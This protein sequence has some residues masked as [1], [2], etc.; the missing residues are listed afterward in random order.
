[1]V[2]L[3]VIGLFEVFV[4]FVFYCLW[5]FV[6]IVVGSEMQLRLLVVFLLFL[7]VQL[8]NFSVFVFCFGLFCFV[9]SSMNV[10]LMIGYVF[11]FGW[12]VRIWQNDFDQFVLVVVVLN[13][14]VFG[15]IIVF[16][17]F[18]RVVQ[19]MLFFFVYVYLM[20]LIVFGRCCMK[21]V[22]LL[23]FL[24]FVFVGQLIVVFLLIFDF[25]LL[26]IFDRQFVQM[27]FVF[28]LLVWWIM[29][30]FVFGS[31][32]FGFSV[33][34][35]GLFYFLILLR[36]MLLSIGFDSVSLLVFMFGMLM[37]GIML[38]I[39]VGNWNRFFF[40]SFLFFSGV[41]ELVKLIVFVMICFRLFD[42]LMFWQLIFELLDCWQFV[43]YFVQ[44]GIVNVLFVFVMLV[45]WVVMVKSVL[46]RLVIVVCINFMRF[47]VCEWMIMVL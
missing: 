42:E 3:V 11:L 6:L 38:L 45:V 24:L 20:Q 2:Y 14:F 30:M 44:I 17:E 10:V 32:I 34:I 27:K 9:C 28:E 8:K 41:F 1:M 29:V 23:L 19:V 25:Y 33:V 18:F 21:V 15:L 7:N 31:L 22:M 5:I 4:I 43:V 40:V 47:L 12:F 39:I 36:Q 16:V 35:V 26:L 37:I 13:V 46:V